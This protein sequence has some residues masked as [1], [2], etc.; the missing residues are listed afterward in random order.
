MHGHKLHIG[1]SGNISVTLA[2]HLW[3]QFQTVGPLCVTQ[4]ETHQEEP[5][6]K[7]QR[8]SS[9]SDAPEQPPPAAAE[10]PINGVEL[11]DTQVRIASSQGSTWP[12]SCLR[13]SGRVGVSSPCR[14][15]AQVCCCTY[16]EKA[17]LGENARHVAQHVWSFESRRC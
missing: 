8:G 3:M 12:S 11:L 17:A 15:A 14:A 16:E 9:G 1:D 5:Q 13:P 7:R 4:E 10:V 6:S 2:T